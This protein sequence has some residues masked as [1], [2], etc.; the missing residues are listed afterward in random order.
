[1]TDTAQPAT[2]AET[3]VASDPIADAANAFRTFDKAAPE[4]PERPRGPDG[5]FVSA[6]PEAEVTEIEAEE[7]EAVA[8]ETEAESPEQAEASEEA[9]E[10]AQPDVDLPPSWPSDMA[11]EWQTLPA[12]V[13]EKIVAREAEREAAVNAKFQEAANLRKA[14]EAE[15]GEAQANRQKFAEAA[16]FLMSVV[17][18]QRPSPSLLDPNSSDYNP[19]AYHL[20]NRKFEEQAQLLNAVAQQRAQLAQQEQAEAEKAREQRI[21]ELNE[22]AMP[23]LIKIVPDFSDQA[24]AQPAFMELAQ[25]ALNQ[26]VPEETELSAFTAVE[27]KL[28]AKA[29]KYD[30]MVAAQAKVTPKAPKP[31]APVVKPGVATPR[32]AVEQQRQKQALNR[33][34]RE[35]SV[36]AAAAYFMTQSRK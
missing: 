36:E 5:K 31:A 13:R 35:G 14:H 33:L 4:T 29:R 27:L 19:D 32:A 34:D 16:D 26:G 8:E 15:I 30:E 7:P 3:V 2:A 21:A 6:Q 17:Q 24:K 11:E 23:D 22:K 10:E 20:A 12:P 25:Y 9:A 18:P 1:M 28:L